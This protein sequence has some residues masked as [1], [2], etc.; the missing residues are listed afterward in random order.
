MKKVFDNLKGEFIVPESEDVQQVEPDSVIGKVIE[1]INIVSK[2]V[3]ELKQEF[4]ELRKD[5]AYNKER[6]SELGKFINGQTEKF[7]TIA[8]WSAKTD[9][10]V[11]KLRL[12]LNKV[13]QR[14]RLDN[15]YRV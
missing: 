2:D 14:M 15:I 11:E 1:Q 4:N 12:T 7:Q 3:A 9:Q 6:I 13:L 10:H 8:F 5:V